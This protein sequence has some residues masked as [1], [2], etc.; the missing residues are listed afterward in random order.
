MPAGISCSMG[1]P[2]GSPV[3]AVHTIGTSCRLEVRT[4]DGLFALCCVGEAP[5]WFLD[6]CRAAGGDVVLF[7]QGGSGNAPEETEGV[8]GRIFLKFSKN[9]LFYC[10]C[11]RKG[12]LCHIILRMKI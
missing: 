7:V 3:V 1:C 4:T 10:V 12:Y 11:G 9:I 6:G 8:G 5:F 2:C